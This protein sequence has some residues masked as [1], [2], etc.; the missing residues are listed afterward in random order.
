MG[1]GQG[2]MEAD[3]PLAGRL[4]AGIIGACSKFE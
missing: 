1:A 3:R 2:L 4:A